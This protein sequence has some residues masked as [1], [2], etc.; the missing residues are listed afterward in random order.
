MKTFL[1]LGGYGNTGK[2]VAELLLKETDCK[3]IIAGRSSDKSKLLADKLN[4]LNPNNRVYFQGLDASN[5][6]QMKT[7][8][9]KVDMV[10]VCSSTLDYYKQI[11]DTAIEEGID[12][13]DINISEQKNQYIMS[14]NEEIIRK[15]L[16][17]VTDGGFHPG[18][19]A[20]MV[21]YAS[22]KY[23]E[24]EKA[25]VYGLM[26][27]NWKE[28]NFSK[29]T[30]LEFVNEFQNYNAAIFKNKKWRKAKTSDFIKIDFGKPYGKHRLY[31]MNLDEMKELPGK[32]MS[33]NETGFYVSGFNWFVDLFVLPFA[34]I[35]LKLF[36]KRALNI[37]GKVF[38]KGLK[39]FTNPPYGIILKL[40]SEGIINGEQRKY[41]MKLIHENGYI[42]TAVPIVAFLK[43]YLNG[44]AKK[45][46]VWYQANIV[47]PEQFFDDIRKMGVNIEESIIEN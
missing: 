40:N 7:A 37:V 12:Y 41:E 10:L 4:L 36:G 17:F 32:Y 3:I 20:A 21:N 47:E 43:Q 22:N 18:V 14:R 45:T 16:C 38:V 31:P 27:L 29:E 11:I 13:Y 28:Y 34:I 44:T 35:T 25:N 6:E 1:I 46:G 9:K 30:I 26:K 19:P 33:L 15:N 39:G 5:K 2:L 23:E 42:V 24:I 8:F